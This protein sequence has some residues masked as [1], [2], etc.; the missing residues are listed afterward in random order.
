MTATEI[1]HAQAL[2]AAANSRSRGRIREAFEEVSF[3]AEAMT[4]DLRC[5]PFDGIED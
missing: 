1:F 3:E 4:E 5:C 2:E